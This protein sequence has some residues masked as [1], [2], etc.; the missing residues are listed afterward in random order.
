MWLALSICGSPVCGF[1]QL[2]S[3]IFRKLR[4]YGI[5]LLYFFF[6]GYSCI[7]QYCNIY[8]IYIMLHI[9]ISPKVIPSLQKIMCHLCGNTTLFCGRGLSVL[10]FGIHLGLSACKHAALFQ[11]EVILFA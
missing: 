6:Y 4:L 3:K 9:K 7:M 5:S 10:S 11:P 1:Y 8:S 2:G